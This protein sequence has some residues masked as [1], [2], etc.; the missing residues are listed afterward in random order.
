MRGTFCRAD[1]GVISGKH[2]GDSHTLQPPAPVTGT[3]F[4]IVML[5]QV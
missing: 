5:L 2:V 3:S 1:I 4:L